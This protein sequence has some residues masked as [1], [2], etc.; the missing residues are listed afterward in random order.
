MTGSPGDWKP[1]M[2]S[3]CFC[4]EMWFGLLEVF[5]CQAELFK[6]VPV[7]WIQVVEE[8]DS[9]PRCRR[10]GGIRLGPYGS[11]RVLD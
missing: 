7:T 2:R 11:G 4:Q 6:E 8:A 9:V 5:F 1:W 10:H 3:G